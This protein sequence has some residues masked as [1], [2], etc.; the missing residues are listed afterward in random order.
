VVFSDDPENPRF[1]LALEGEVIVDV[2]M[3][4]RRLAFGSLRRGE[5][6][7]KEF[8]LKVRDPNEIQ[9]E[10]V[11]LEDERFKL[12][13]KDESE[14]GGSTYEVEFLGSDEYERIRAKVRLAVT[15]TKAKDH[16]LHI[17]A[18]V[19]SDL[20]FPQRVHFSARDGTFRDRHIT[21][22]S[23][24]GNPVEIL[25]FEDH[26]DMLSCEIVANK[27]ARARL[28]CKVKENKVPEKESEAHKLTVST[29]DKERPK[30][31]IE[32]FLRKPPAR[33]HRGDPP[34]KPATLVEKTGR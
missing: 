3:E 12:T 4:P 30:V 7:T 21:L 10:S 33:L 9:I 17:S 20:R 13:K 5:T 23:R 1:E 15:G 16:F 28:L 19:D 11:S 26:D 29:T 34:A 24:S 32:Y 27:E 6:A 2:L 25:S 18:S 8:K 22:S 31:D 14:D